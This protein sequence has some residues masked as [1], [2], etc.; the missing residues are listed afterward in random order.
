MGKAFQCFCVPRGR[1]N[2]LF[3]IFQLAFGGGW[4]FISTSPPPHRNVKIKVSNEK[5]GRGSVFLNGSRQL[6]NNN[7]IGSSLLIFTQLK[8]I[9]VG[10]IMDLWE[11]HKCTWMCEDE[12]DRE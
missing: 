10:N 6:P 7:V 8:Y 5:K 11:V 9:V 3:N 1:E 12:G 4:A 2:I